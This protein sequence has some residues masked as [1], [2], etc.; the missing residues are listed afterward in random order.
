M[1]DEERRVALFQA[2][3]EE[4]GLFFRPTALSLAYVE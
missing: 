4:P 3:P 1:N 2:Q